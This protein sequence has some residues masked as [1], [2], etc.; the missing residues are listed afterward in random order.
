MELIPPTRPPNSQFGA[1][2]FCAPDVQ[3]PHPPIF[4]LGCYNAFMRRRGYIEPRNI[5]V[6]DDVMAEA[7]R[8]MGGPRRLK[9]A[10]QMHAGT[11]AMLRHKL[12]KENPMWDQERLKLEVGRRLLNG[13]F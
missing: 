9:A 10:S 5:E 11:R 8:R 13:A 6:I 3:K 1:G 4:A 7:L 2:S 12:A